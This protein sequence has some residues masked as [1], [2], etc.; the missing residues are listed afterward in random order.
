MS[1]NVFSGA[2]TAQGCRRSNQDAYVCRP[3]L[4]TYNLYVMCDGLGG[5]RAGEVA[6]GTAVNTIPVY[7]ELFGSDN[8][9]GACAL[10]AAACEMA[11]S[12]IVDT[13]KRD[14]LNCRG[15]GTTIVVLLHELD[16]V[17]IAY[18]GDSRC[19]RLRAGRLELLSWDHNGLREVDEM[20]QALQEAD[21]PI[22]EHLEAW[23]KSPHAHD[24][25][26]FLGVD[27]SDPKALGSPIPDLRTEPLVSYDR[28]LLCSDGVHGRHA[29]ADSEIREI[30]SCSAD[31]QEAA[32]ALVA[33]AI[34]KDPVH[35]DNATAIVI[36]FVS[37]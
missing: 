16:R 33:A 20:I 22:P 8:V 7:I 31:P 37:S 1:W 35:A 15:M 12:R 36:D 25:S 24:L 28:F 17:H 3:R 19:Y 18:V 30:L 11:N 29:L 21:Q 14:P 34:A 9:G 10:L 32:D 27:S 2:C 13:A 23:K 26:R 4:R 5:R 6:S